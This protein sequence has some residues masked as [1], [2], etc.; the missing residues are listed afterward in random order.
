[1]K[2]IIT[3]FLIIFSSI[4][5]FGQSNAKQYIDQYKNV[6]LQQMIETNIPASIILAQGIIES[7]V[8]TNTLA[9]QANNHF[10][11]KCTKSWKGEALFKLKD[12]EDFCYKVYNSPAESYIEHTTLIV[13]DPKFENL[14]FIESTNYKRWAKGLEALNYSSSPGYANQLIQTIELYKLYEI[15]EN[16]DLYKEDSNVEADEGFETP[17]KSNEDVLYVNDVKAVVAS[18]KETPLEFA[19]RMKIPLRKVLK[20]NDITLSQDFYPGQY[21]FLD[22]KKS[23]YTKDLE[24]HEVR[25][26]DNIY[27]I[28]QQYGIRLNKL[29]KMNRLK[30]GEE[31][32]EGETIYLKDKAPEKPILRSAKFSPRVTPIIKE[33]KPPVTPPVR[34]ITPPT[35]ETEETG[36]EQPTK[37]TK[38]T[39]PVTTTNPQKED[40]EVGKEEVTTNIEPKPNESPIV[41]TPSKPTANEPAEKPANTPTTNANQVTKK[42]HVVDRGET[43]Y[44]IAKKYNVTVQRLKDLNGL[45]SNEIEINQRIRYE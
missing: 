12:N 6:A 44:G 11:I 5:V 37:P 10:G 45:L 41:P 15:D 19:A 7:S 23:K 21:V 32:K 35:T 36:N 16:I 14:F 27:L 38:P 8:G 43:L 13:N 9:K 39:K 26:T 30:F 33:E 34:I 31:P 25:E 17:Y 40:N 24:V 22:K 4:V 29:L 18:G 28:A 42:I 3:L 2:S 1:M 20:Y